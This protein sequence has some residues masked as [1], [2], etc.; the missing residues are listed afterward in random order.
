MGEV[1]RN[2]AKPGN[3]DELDGDSCLVSLANV[4]T[5]GKIMQNGNE[6]YE[7]LAEAPERVDNEEPEIPHVDEAI[8]QSDVMDHLKSVDANQEGAD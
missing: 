3:Q 6:A 4:L 8:A 1:K 7:S 5:K 2:E